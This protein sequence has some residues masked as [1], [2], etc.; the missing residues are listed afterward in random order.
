MHPLRCMEEYA[1]KTGD[2]TNGVTYGN[3]VARLPWPSATK[4][5]KHRSCLCPC[6][7]VFSTDHVSSWNFRFA[8][9]YSIILLSPSNADPTETYFLPLKIFFH[10][11]SF[12]LTSNFTTVCSFFV[13]PEETLQNKRSPQSV[14][15]F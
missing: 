5:L 13:P 14:K 11:L 8:R 10:F 15:T 6:S 1:R 3:I 4:L 12:D 9:R 7:P 2:A